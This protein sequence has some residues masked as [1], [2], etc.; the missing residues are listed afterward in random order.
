MFIVC[1][2]TTRREH[3]QCIAHS[4]A[5]LHSTRLPFHHTSFP[6]RSQEI[7][8]LEFHRMLFVCLFFLYKLT[9]RNLLASLR[10]LLIRYS[11]ASSLD[12]LPRFHAD[13]LKLELFVWYSMLFIAMWKIFFILEYQ[14]AKILQFPIPNKSFYFLYKIYKAISNFRA[15]KRIGSLF[16]LLISRLAWVL[17][18]RD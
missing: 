10:Y 3:A 15:L 18:S 1:F 6:L 14:R 11:L 2:W 7:H 13:A 4:T 16:L 12:V 17:L 5:L 9:N 8:N